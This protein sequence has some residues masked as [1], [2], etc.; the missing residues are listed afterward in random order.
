MDIISEQML[1][2]KENNLAAQLPSKDV[3][4]TAL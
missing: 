1:H 4:P 3:Q 2:A